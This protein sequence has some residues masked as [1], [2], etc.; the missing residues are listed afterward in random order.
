MPKAKINGVELFWEEAGSGDDVLLMLHGFP[1]DH[2]MWLDQMAHFSKLGWRVIAP[3]QRGYG[4]SS[5]DPTED[6]TMDLLAQDAAALLDYLGVKKAVVMGLSMGGYVTFAFYRQFPEKVRAL[7][8]ANTKAEPDAPVARENRYKLREVVRQQG[9]TAARDVMLPAMFSP[10]LHQSGGTLLDNLEAIMV[11]TRPTAIISTLPG[12]AERRD[13]VPD[14]PGIGV[15]TL[16]IHGEL[17]QLM[18]VENARRMA[19]ANPQARFVGVPGA[20]HMSNLEN[21]AF[22]NRAVEE[23]LAGLK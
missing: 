9:S 4:Q 23:F 5:H 7:I 15:P 3:D 19:Q 1:L 21:S 10:E 2:T 20:G 13:V 12:L 22:F 11:R 16:V 6:N 18:P 8:L 14:L 17:D